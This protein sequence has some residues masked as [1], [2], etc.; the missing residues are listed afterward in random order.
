MHLVREDEDEVVEDH[1]PLVHFIARKLVSSALVPAHVEYVDLVADGMLALIEAHRRYDVG[2][3]VRFSTFAYMRVRGAMLDGIRKSEGRTYRPELVDITNVVLL[4]PGNLE[5]QFDD[6]SALLDALEHLNPRLRVVI[7]RHFV[8]E[9]TLHQV[10]Q[11]MGLSESRVCQLKK[12]AL[13]EIRSW[14]T[15]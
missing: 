11:F 5:E 13:S 7:V 3:G 15:A 9:E 8:L 14:I 4:C 10:A 12:Q 6:T 2:R 1:A